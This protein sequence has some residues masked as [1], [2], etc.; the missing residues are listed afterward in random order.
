M[1][2]MQVRTDASCGVERLGEIE[3]ELKQR[4]SSTLSLQLAR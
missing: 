2:A 1:A 4:G 3:F